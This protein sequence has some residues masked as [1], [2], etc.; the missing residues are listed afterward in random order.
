MLDTA[1]VRRSIYPLK[2]G[3]GGGSVVLPSAVSLFRR[4]KRLMPLLH[5]DD[6]ARFT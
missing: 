2:L 5:Y 6:A 3:R 4:F 1:E